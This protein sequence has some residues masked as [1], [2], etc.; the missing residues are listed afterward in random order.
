MNKIKHFSELKPNHIYTDYYF[1]GSYM[2][3]EMRNS[4]LA[5]FYPEYYDDEKEEILFNKNIE[6]YFT[7]N[8][9][10]KLFEN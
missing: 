3:V 4:Q 7:L 5:T 9:I 8:E 1:G 2:F 10:Q 6:R